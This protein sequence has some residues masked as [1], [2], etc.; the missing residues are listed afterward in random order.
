MQLKG[1]PNKLFEIVPILQPLTLRG[2]TRKDEVVIH[3]IRIGHTRLTHRYLM[4][5][6]LKR[7]PPCNFCYLDWLSIKHLMIDCQHF[8]N[9]R[10][11]YY[12]VNN[13]KELFDRV[14]LRC[15][16]NFLKAANLYNN[17]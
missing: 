11:N 17:I 6:P 7:E 5:D 9:I 12:S 15:I 16:L 4:E 13:M 2:Y 1:R 3:R 8:D 10:I 14:P